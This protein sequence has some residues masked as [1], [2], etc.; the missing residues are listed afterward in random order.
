MSKYEKFVVQNPVDHGEMRYTENPVYDANVWYMGNADFGGAPFSQVFVRI[1]RDFV[2]EEASHTHDFD[3]WVWHIPLDP[4]NIEDLG[5][6]VEMVY[7]AGTEDD[8]IEKYTVTKNSCFYVPAGTVH[9]PYTFRNVTKPML[10]I[11]TM[12]SEGY[13][14]GKKE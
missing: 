3:M 6:E 4:D 1:D 14:K 9:G 12:T 5:G 13:Y 8:P 7:G 10:F 2:M 11:H